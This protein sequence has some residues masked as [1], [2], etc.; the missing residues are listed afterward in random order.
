MKRTKVILLA[1]AILPAIVAWTVGGGSATLQPGSRLWVTGT[2]T[3]R[4]FTCQ[5]KIVDA[6][7]GTAGAQA[8]REVVGGAKSVLAL[9]VKVRPENL[10]CAN[11]TM[12]EHMRKALKIDA[13]PVIE[14][15]ML[16]YD[17]SKASA[18][19]S[20]RLTGTLTLGGV[21]KQITFDA[22]GTAP[23]SGA[24]HVTGVYPILMSDYGLKAPSLMMGAMKV[25]N[26]VKVN[27]DLLVK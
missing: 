23:A 13:N 26:R 3:V 6:T 7:I 22:V 4:D 10:D 15:K 18:T 11:T 8:A 17:I 5:A 27:F 25:N 14:F 19:T 16:S 24:L 9:D 20:G 12:N 2:S 21:Q 1:A